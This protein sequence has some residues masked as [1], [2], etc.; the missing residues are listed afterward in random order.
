MGEGPPADPAELLRLV[1]REAGLDLATLTPTAR[2]ESGAAFWVTDDAGTTSLLK[3]MPGPAA[4][5]AGY[6]HALDATLGRLRERGYPAPRLRA[7]GR[8]AGFGFW[9]QERMAGT[10]LE[11]AAGQPH[12]ELITRL[13]PELI[14]LN[15]AQ[16]GLG[17]AADGQPGWPGLISATLATGGD[18]Y[19]LHATLAARPGSR[20]LL[21]VLRRTGADCC[22]TISCISTSTWPT[23]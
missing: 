16:A 1:R 19:C 5:A 3:I 10:T 23:C 6:L 9:I 22:P 2:G 14:R 20:D 15:D 21:E 11:S 18:G 8:T 7:I 13:L 4:A 17:R 12:G